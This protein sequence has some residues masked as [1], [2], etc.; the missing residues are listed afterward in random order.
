MSEQAGQSTTENDKCVVLLKSGARLSPLE[1]AK[2]LDLAM[3][4][5]ESVGTTDVYSRTQMAKAWMERY[6]PQWAA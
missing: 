4:I 5:I 3:Q 2:A 1:A 6:Y